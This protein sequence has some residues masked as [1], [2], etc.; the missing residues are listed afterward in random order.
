MGHYPDSE[1]IHTS[2]SGTLA[3]Q[4][5][6]QAR[7]LIQNEEYRQIFPRVD[8][9]HDSN[10]RN[11]WKT[12]AGGAFYSTGSMGTITGFGAGN[13]T[14]HFGGAILID[15]PHKADEAR[16]PVKRGA[17]IEWFSTTLESRKNTED[18]PIIL[19]MQRLHQEDLAG[20]LLGGG[21][22]EEWEHI[23]L[24]AIQGDGTALWEDK[25]DVDTLLR[26]QKS[27]P[28][29]FAGQ[30]QQNPVVSGGNIIKSEWFGRYSV[31]P[32]LEYRIIIA[33]TAQKTKER[34]DYSVFACYGKGVDGRVYVVDVLRGKWEAPELRRAAVDFW[35]KHESQND[36]K[37]VGM[38]REMLVEDKSSGTGL[39]QQIRRDASCP[40]TP[41]QRQRDKLTRL[42]D[43][44]GY[45]ESGYI[46]FPESSAWVS[47]FVA[48]CEAFAA[49]DSH[50]HDD[51][52]D[53][54]ID[55]ITEMLVGGGFD[56]SA[57]L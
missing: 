17:V 3:G 25:H 21:N 5:A 57:L 7:E 11:F 15:D 38:L 51:Q 18:T 14:D 46:L 54:L 30:Y 40:I 39:I 10:A 55:A 2:Y 56:L 47:D 53:T 23:C 19:I 34:N 16:S 50:A 13:H 36:P 8:L 12:T 35:K 1:F 28:Y 33:D 49:D 41:I 37:T 48:E 6:F 52:V 9:R 4:N 43:V 44:V 45:I 42:M 27:N 29:V 31:L 24:P 22:N 32:K 20:W 26:L